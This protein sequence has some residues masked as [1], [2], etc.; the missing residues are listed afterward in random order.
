MPIRY[1]NHRLLLNSS[2]IKP[3]VVL[4]LVGPISSHAA[5]YEYVVEAMTRV[6]FIENPRRSA[7]SGENEIL[8]EQ[9]L[10]GMLNRATSKLLTTI[11]YQASNYNYKE[12][13]Q[14]DRTFITGSS[15]I[16]WI[17]VPERFSWNL[18]NTRSLQV[19]NSLLPDTMDNR[20]VI[21][22]TSTGPDFTFQLTG[23]DKFGGGVD[24]SI[25]DYENAALS[26]QDR[27]SANVLLS[28]SFPQRWITSI[29]GNYL[30]SEFKD[31][32][33][34]DFDRYEYFWQNEYL[35]EVL[36][37]T[38]KLGQNILARES[39][40][41]QENFLIRFNG[42]YT[43]NSRSVF[44]FNYSDS[45]EDIFSNMLFSPTNA[46]TPLIG[47]R[48]GNTNLNQNFQLVNWGIGY[49]YTRNEFLNVNVRY[50]HA[51]RTY[52]GLPTDI[53]PFGVPIDPNT[54]D[55]TDPNQID[56]TDPNQLDLL[57]NQNQRDKTLSIGA[58]WTPYENVDL[59]AYASFTNQV[60][61]DVNR[62]QRRGEYGL[63]A[64]YRI[65]QSLYTQFSIF[66]IKQT[67]NVAFDRYDGINCAISLTLTIG[68]S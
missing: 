7:S 37:M 56:P 53:N 36:D 38:L 63:Q 54:F 21:S 26:R 2:V 42:T 43:A 39:S 18:A 65:S 46:I 24:Y 47:A 6:E 64:G 62:K 48:L 10:R 13:L 31:F 3:L 15:S 66:G 34:L 14:E 27:K 49:T 16:D 12:D 8:F 60:F 28:H 40:E 50:T 33:I 59:G 67:G 23:R 25:A 4:Y 68:N 17:I 61:S 20:Q 9:R 55:P 51:D 11:D 30:Q 32:P 58:N 5:E 44:D 35:S 57:I 22:L 52:Q 19:V 1:L 41:E 29:G 45:Y